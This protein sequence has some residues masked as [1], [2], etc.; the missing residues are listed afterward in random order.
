MIL[1]VLSR[2]DCNT[3]HLCSLG[4]RNIM[5]CIGK[6]ITNSVKMADVWLIPKGAEKLIDW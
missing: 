3:R 4:K 2:Q 1:S 5:Y 6:S